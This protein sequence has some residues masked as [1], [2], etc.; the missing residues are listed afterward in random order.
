[1]KLYYI[2]SL[3]IFITI[4]NYSIAQQLIPDKYCVSA[5]EKEMLKL[6]N[7]YR[8]SKKLPAI[9][10]SSELTKVAKIHANDLNTNHPNNGKCNMH[11]WSDKGKWEPCCYTDDHKKAA[12][13]WSKPSEL[14]NY[15]GNGYEIAYES[16]DT[17]SPKEALALWKKSPGHNSVIIQSGIFKN[18]KWKAIGI[19][20]E[21]NYI[22][23]WFGTEPD[24]EAALEECK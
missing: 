14:T 12:L 20:V 15:K 13:M 18:S 11:S 16:S 9:T 24:T 7:E 8:K 17:P 23:I 19:A 4:N 1:M 5:Q 3:I 22:L 2:F 10:L 6:I 21:G